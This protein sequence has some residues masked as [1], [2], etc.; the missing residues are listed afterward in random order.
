M[1]NF[2]VNKH[3]KDSVTPKHGGTATKKDSGF[4]QHIANKPSANLEKKQT[5]KNVS[6]YTK[7]GIHNSQD[8]MV[9]KD[10]A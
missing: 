7:E 6:R 9:V 10:L 2:E 4:T 8:D 3:P 1:G 5:S